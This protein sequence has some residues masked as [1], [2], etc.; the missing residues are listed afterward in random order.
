MNI[1]QL[2]LQDFF[3]HEQ[4]NTIL[5]VLISFTINLLQINGISFITANIINFIQKNN[6]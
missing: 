6:K 4:F 5:L 3:Y 2:L 1:V